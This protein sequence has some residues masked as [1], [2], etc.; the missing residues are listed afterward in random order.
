MW[1]AILKQADLFIPMLPSNEL[2]AAN[3]GIDIPW[4]PDSSERLDSSHFLAGY[5]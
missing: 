1:K 5:M 4:L 2:D 3:L